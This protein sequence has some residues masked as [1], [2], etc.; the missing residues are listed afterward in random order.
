MMPLNCT[1]DLQQLSFRLARQGFGVRPA[2][3]FTSN[4]VLAFILDAGG[5]VGSVMARTVFLY[6][7]SEGWCARITQHGG[8][9]WTR[10]AEDISALERIALEALQRAEVPPS[11]AWVEENDGGP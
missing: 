9:H 2:P 8:R 10:T 11:S 5:C 4:G 7:T 3:Y 1:S 6:V